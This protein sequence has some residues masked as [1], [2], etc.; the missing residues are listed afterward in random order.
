MEMGS[1]LPSAMGT[2]AKPQ[3]RSSVAV[4]SPESAFA[5][6]R[7]LRKLAGEVGLSPRETEELALV[8]SEL[9]TNIVKYAPRG[10]IEVSLT[11]DL[12]H[13]PGIR[14]IAEDDGEMFDLTAALRDGY[15]ATGA[16]DPARLY[17]RRGIGA[18][19][20][21]VARLTD[22]LQIES[23]APPGS[24]KGKR[25]VAIR[26]AKRPRRPSV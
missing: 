16:I 22:V 20:G 15:D 2:N 13:G 24:T 19:L 23:T 11:A 12:E 8:V 9:A 17:G 21:A 4:G 6:R 5:A 7:V 10:R 26:W 1:G 25:I 18:G 3:P 14:I